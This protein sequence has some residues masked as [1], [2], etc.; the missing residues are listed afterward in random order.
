LKRKASQDNLVSIL[1]PARNEANNIAN[2]LND[3]L[4]QEYKNIEII[5][6]NDQSCDNTQQIVEEFVQKDNRIKLINSTQLPKNWMGKNYACH[7]MSL[8][9]NGKYFLFLDADIRIFS[10]II[11]TTIYHLQEKKLGLL[12]IFPKQKMQSY[13]EKITVPLM[14]YI[15]LTL[16]PLVFVRKSNFTSLSAANGQFML[17]SADV[18]KS[19]Y[20]HYTMRN[21]RVEDIKIARFLKKKKI[22]IACITGNNNIICRMYQNFTEAVEGFAKNIN[23]FFGNSYFVA[24]LFWFITTFGFIFIIPFGIEISL[25]YLISYFITRILTSVVSKQAIITNLLLIIPQQICLGIIIYTSIT[26][27]IKRKQKWKGRE[28]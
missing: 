7:Q 27:R 3:I 18:Y 13:G 9:A 17:F 25:L 24:S 11:S 15:L 28:I 12:S 4:V 2:I 21:Q 14:N 1:I 6:F 19:Y 10:D 5:V 22:R 26:N 8:V 16:L 23:M 20:L